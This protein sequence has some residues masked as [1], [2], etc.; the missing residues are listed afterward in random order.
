M[1]YTWH[2]PYQQFLTQEQAMH[3]AGN[4]LDFFQGTDWTKLSLSA[5]IGNMWA[6]SRVNPNMYELG[7][8]WDQDRGFGLVQWTPRSKYWN[9][10]L[11]QGYSTSELRNGDVQLARIQYEVDSNIQWLRRYDYP[12]SFA[13]FRQNSMNASLETL[14]EMF[15]WCYE[16][17][18]QSAGEQSLPDRIGFARAVMELD[19]DGGYKVVYPVDISDPGI[20]ETSPYGWRMHP[21]YG[22]WRFHDGQDWGSGGRQVPIY[23]T[24]DGTVAVAVHGHNSLGNYITINHQY[25]EYFSRYLHLSAIQVTLGQ[26]VRAGQQIG[27]MGTT[28]DSTGIHLHFT[29]AT[30]LNGFGEDYTID[31]MWYLR[32]AGQ[33]GHEPPG[34]VQKSGLKVWQMI[35]YY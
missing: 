21:I 16:R 24:T 13:E 7:Y 30:G 6:E 4:I 10:A 18:N 14:V 15:M 3:N 23:A 20:V 29:I 33:G 34:S 27:L 19:F 26:E 25:D 31:P 5:M 22:D 35:K 12:Y 28:G 32:N 9:W 17:P 1:A 8:D 2:N 11:D